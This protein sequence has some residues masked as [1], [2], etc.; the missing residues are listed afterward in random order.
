VGSEMTARILIVLI[1][2]FSAFGI[3]TTAFAQNTAP[4]ILG[5]TSFGDL[6]YPIAALAAHEDGR[7]VLDLSISPNGI[8]SDAHIATSTGSEALDRASIRVAKG[9]WRF[10]PAMQNGQPVAGTTQVAAT[11]SLPLTPTTQ[12]YIDI[13][14]SQGATLATPSS[15]YEARHLDYPPAAAA[16]HAQGVVGVRYQ[17][18]AAGSV[19][20]AAL[21]QPSDNWRFDAAAL[22]I[23][24][25]R[26]FA[27]ATRN[28]APVTAWQGLTVSFSILP[29]NASRLDPPCY[30]QPILARDA[31]LV[32]ATPHRVEVWFDSARYRTRWET[33]A[34][35]DWIGTWVQVSD[36]GAPTEVILF[37]EEGWM[38]PSQPIASRL[39][40][41]RDYPNGR[42][43]C[44]YFDPISILG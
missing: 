14:D 41:G 11:W 37:T 4:R 15:A 25:N 36:S 35:T 16:S 6:D 1:T 9:Q 17:V 32:G 34:V 5:S 42:G 18:D 28:G 8:V 26:S 39:T 22:R 30:A 2:I 23:A 12:N 21:V 33:R 20:D 29:A 38:V 3:G 13:P 40:G 44:W 31:V 24:Q 19:T 43:G 27:P 10:A 7:V